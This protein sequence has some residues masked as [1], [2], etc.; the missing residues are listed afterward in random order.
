V[1][2]SS[3]KRQDGKRGRRKRSRKKL[4]MHRI[5]SGPKGEIDKKSKCGGD[6]THGPPQGGVSDLKKENS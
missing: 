2:Q 3:E 1:Q 5:W 6:G 4:G